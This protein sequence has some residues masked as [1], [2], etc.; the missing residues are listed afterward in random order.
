MLYK[1]SIDCFVKTVSAKYRVTVDGGTDCWLE[2]VSS[3]PNKDRIKNVYPDLTTGDF[4]SVKQETLEKCKQA[5]VKV[6][7]TPDQ[8]YT[9][10]E[11]AFKETVKHSDGK[12]C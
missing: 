6:V 11:K 12:V 2:F 4:D 9:D 7:H 5:G 10:F 1:F 8:D 3:T